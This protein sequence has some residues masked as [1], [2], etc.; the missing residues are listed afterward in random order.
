MVW[1]R[2]GPGPTQQA[3]TDTLFSLK[4]C[5]LF[6]ESL[7]FIGAPKEQINESTESKLTPRL[8]FIPRSCSL[9]GNHPLKA[10][11]TEGW[12]WGCVEESEG[13]TL[14]GKRGRSGGSR[15]PW[16]REG[17]PGAPPEGL[18]SSDALPWWERAVHSGRG[19]P[20]Q[21]L[22]AWSAVVSRFLSIVLSDHVVLG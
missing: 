13:Q 14:W 6:P 17:R 15:E 18:R 5:G 12:D 3:S 7:S 10:R 20:G 21:G 9:A 8:I 1:G 11:D 4:A 16:G 22:L 2:A 19:G